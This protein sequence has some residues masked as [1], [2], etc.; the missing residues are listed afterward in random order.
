[1]TFDLKTFSVCEITGTD[2]IA[3]YIIKQGY[4]TGDAEPS[5]DFIKITVR[6]WENVHDDK[7]KIVEGFEWLENVIEP[8][9]EIWIC[10]TIQDGKIIDWWITGD[11]I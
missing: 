9:L 4:T 1:M 8:N 2:V 6:E 10:W 5:G 11:D 3:K 7:P